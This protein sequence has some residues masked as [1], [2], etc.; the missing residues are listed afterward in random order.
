VVQAEAGAAYARDLGAR[1]VAVITD[2]TEYGDLVS[3]EFTEEAPSEGLSIVAE[4]RRRA[5]G[6]SGIAGLLERGSFCRADLVY[7]AGESPGLLPAQPRDRSCGS[8]LL[9]TDALSAPA[10]RHLDS[11]PLHLT[12]AA[13]A[14]EQL[15]PAGQE[16]VRTYRQEYGREPDPY[17]AYGYE[18]MALVLDAI[19]RAGSEG[20]DRSA[21]MDELLATTDRDSLLGTYSIDAAGDTTLDAIAGYRIERGEPVF[22]RGLTAP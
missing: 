1:R 17:A 16:F 13:Q 19:E 3:G 6:A 2:G 4:A 10:D 22:D 15:P 18:A 7:L 11:S 21:V 9:G 5:S 20:E 14:P 12:A 8:T